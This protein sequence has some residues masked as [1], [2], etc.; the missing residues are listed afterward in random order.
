MPKSLSRECRPVLPGVTRPAA[1]TFH[2][3]RCPGAC[4]G[5][6]VGSALHRVPGPQ[7]T[8]LWSLLGP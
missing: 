5:R 8:P 2:L 3:H 7:G 1:S 4:V 6:G